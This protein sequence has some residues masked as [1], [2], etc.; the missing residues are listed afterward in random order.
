[1][2]ETFNVGET[3]YFL[4]HFGINTG[5]IKKINI[6]KQTSDLFDLQTH[7]I[8]LYT[9]ETTSGTLNCIDLDVFKTYGEALNAKTLRIKNKIREYETKI[10]NVP[11]LLSFMISQMHCEEYT[12]YEAIE[13]SKNK[14][15]ELLGIEI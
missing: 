15:K 2:T 1:M 12:D 5:K 13:A 9:I 3:V 6:A 14:I 11:E 7:N 10:T 4:D 8:M